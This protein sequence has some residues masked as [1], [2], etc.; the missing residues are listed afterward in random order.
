MKGHSHTSFKTFHFLRAIDAPNTFHFYK[1]IRQLLLQVANGTSEILVGRNG[2]PLFPN[3]YK[4]LINWQVQPWNSCLQFASWL[5]KYCFV[6]DC[7]IE[8]F[9]RGETIQSYGTY[10]YVCFLLECMHCNVGEKQGDGHG[11]RDVKIKPLGWVVSRN[12]KVPPLPNFDWI[13]QRRPP[14]ICNQIGM[15][16]QKRMTLICQIPTR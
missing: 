6:L 12:L 9:L 13:Q 16:T 3:S 14:M 11:G 15:F 10:M 7:W 8:E 4:W 5:S 2:K 1:E